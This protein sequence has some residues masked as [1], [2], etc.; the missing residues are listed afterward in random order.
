MHVVAATVDNEGFLAVDGV[1]R[2]GAVGEPAPS[3][4]LRDG[5]HLHWFHNGEAAWVRRYDDTGARRHRVL[6]VNC[7]STRGFYLPPEHLVS[8]ALPNRVTISDKSRCF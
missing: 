8:C 1:S 7:K 6:G 2:K 4:L 5:Y 3:C